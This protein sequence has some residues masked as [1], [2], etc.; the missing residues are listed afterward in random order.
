M[1]SA[2]AS[3][4]PSPVEGLSRRD[5]VGFCTTLSQRDGLAPAYRVHVDGEDVEW[6][7]ANGYRLPYV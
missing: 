7:A 3:C 2:M 6:V 5:A 1:L 4:E